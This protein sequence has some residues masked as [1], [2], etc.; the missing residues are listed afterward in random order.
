MPITRRNMIMGLIALPG[1]EG[2]PDTLES[3][4]NSESG[5]AAKLINAARRQKGVTTLYDPAY[6]HLDY[7]GG[8]VPE[9]RGVCI[10]VVIRA[11]RM[12][13]DFDFQSAVHADMTANFAR[14]PTIWGLTRP[15]RNIDHRRVPNL[16][17]WLE[18]EGHALTSEDWQI[19]DLITCRLPGNLPHIAIIARPA[20][21]RSLMT[22]VIQNIGRGTREEPL[23][24]TGLR[25]VRHFR[26][27][28]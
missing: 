25:N 10:D 15:D 18:R 6:V 22:H 27:L 13:F 26:F 8:D 9:D 28:P 3:L 1:L 20:P 12:A 17:T 4:R 5:K 16:E 24:L 7:P 21:S 11:Y 23:L 19:G 14:Y 2:L